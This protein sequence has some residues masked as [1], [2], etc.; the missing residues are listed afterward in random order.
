[1]KKV[2]TYGT[3]D[4]LHYGH[5]NLLK[6][7]KQLGDYLIVGVTAND[8]DISRGKINVQQSLIERIEA[9]KATGLADEIIIEE[10]EGQKIDDIKKYSVDIFTVGSDWEG[11]FDYLSEYCEVVY[12]PRTQG[13]SSTELRSELTALKIGVVGD[14]FNIFDKFLRESQYVNGVVVKGYFVDNGISGHTNN[15]HMQYKT[16]EELIDNVDAVYIISHPSKHY[17]QIKYA[18][19]NK[20][21]VIVEAPVSLKEEDTKKL[22]ELAVEKGCVLMEAIRTAYSTA[23]SR[24]LLMI[25]SGLIGRVVSVDTTCTSLRNY[26]GDSDFS[27]IWNSIFAWGPIALLPIFQILGVNY[28]D[29]QIIS[30]L[31]DVATNYDDFTKIN[32]NYETATATLKVGKGVKSEGEMVVSGTKGYIYVPAPWWKTDYFEVRYENQSENK[33]CFYQLDGEGIRNE[34]VSFKKMVEGKDYYNE[35]N[36]SI[37]LAIGKVIEDFVNKRDFYELSIQKNKKD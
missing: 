11:K 27:V 33:R 25:K 35:V 34:L 6:R 37:S 22:Y 31:S 36:H 9:I 28:I 32:F 12:L 15:I 18:L 1:M 13:V 2:I 5:V 19:T 17:E 7:A 10:Y 16:Y 20:T 14:D 4:Y 3:Y 8:F 30:L 24:M 26:S 23:Y 21:H 29:K